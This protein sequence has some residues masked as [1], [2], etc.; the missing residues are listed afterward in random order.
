M[1]TNI[2]L[3]ILILILLGISILV[4]TWWVKYGKKIFNTIS[5]ISS[6]SSN[7]G[8]SKPT[9]DVGQLLNEMNKIN[10]IFKK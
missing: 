5:K 3:L 8:M 9:L 10:K 1:V 6:L 4:I 7:N 2:L